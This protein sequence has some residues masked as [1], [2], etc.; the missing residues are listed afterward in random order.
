MHCVA[1]EVAQKV[2]VL[3]EDGDLDACAGQHQSQEESC[4]AATDDRACRCIAHVD[5]VAPRPRWARWIPKLNDLETEQGCEAAHSRGYIVSA[6]TTRGASTCLKRTT[7]RCSR[8]RSPP[9]LRP[10]PVHTCG[11]AS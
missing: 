6:I 4:G 5:I 1:T 11:G 2:S 8:P 3:L 7:V 9:V 10:G